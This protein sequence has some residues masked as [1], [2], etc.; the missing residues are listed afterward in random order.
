MYKFNL[1][2]HIT[3]VTINIIIVSSEGVIVIAQ[4]IEH[5]PLVH[6]VVCSPLAGG[7]NFQEC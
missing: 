6:K 5:P 3:K 7:K 4:W 2:I 1:N